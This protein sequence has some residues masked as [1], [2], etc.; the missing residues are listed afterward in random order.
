M[1]Y[2]R[3]AAILTDE[4]A[5]RAEIALLW[6]GCPTERRWS[7]FHVRLTMRL[8][9]GLQHGRERSDVD[10][11]ERPKLLALGLRANDPPE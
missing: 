7:E 4:G 1:T 8:R 5:D 11:D 6:R 9:R 2:D 10:D 3:F